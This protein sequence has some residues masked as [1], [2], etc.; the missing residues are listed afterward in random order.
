LNLKCDILVFLVFKVCFLNGST[1]GRYNAAAEL[2][3]IAERVLEP[4]RMK[5]G[6]G[7]HELLLTHFEQELAAREPDAKGSNGRGGAVQVAC[8]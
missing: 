4:Q 8:S 7:S 3:S 5:L 1:C 2:M 6:E